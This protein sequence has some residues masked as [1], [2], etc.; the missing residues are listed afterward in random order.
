MRMHKASRKWCRCKRAVSAIVIAF[1]LWLSIAAPMAMFPRVRDL[2]DWPSLSLDSRR[3][4]HRHDFV[5]E[6]GWP[7]VCM[8]CYSTRWGIA[9]PIDREARHWS[10]GWTRGAEET[11]R[12]ARQ[13]KQLAKDRLQ[14]DAWA[15]PDWETKLAQMETYPLGYRWVVHWGRLSAT[16]VL[17]A[18]TCTLLLLFA[19]LMVV[20]RRRRRRRAGLCAYCGYDVRASVQFQR[21][22]ECGIPLH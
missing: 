14:Y 8:E 16:T 19:R 2:G 6:L 4:L 20:L 12:V 17:A 3:D 22:P 15:P 10:M 5:T 21:C 13:W 7:M 1:S 9:R 11:N 18:G